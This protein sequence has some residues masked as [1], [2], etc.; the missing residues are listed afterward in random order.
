M[1]SLVVS[2]VAHADV[3]PAFNA[4]RCRTE[5]KK[6]QIHFAVTKNQPLA[7]YWI[8]DDRVTVLSNQV[9]EM[10]HVVVGLGDGG[11]LKHI[12]NFDQGF[13]REVKIPSGRVTKDVRGM[14]C[15]YCPVELDYCPGQFEN[16]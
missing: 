1:A 16:N 4:V 3:D 10:D 15:V 12:L 5:D 11:T 13:Y 8:E 9:E 14:T 7:L 2:S 6:I